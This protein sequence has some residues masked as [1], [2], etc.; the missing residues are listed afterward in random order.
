MTQ[1]RD[2]ERAQFEIFK[3]LP[4]DTPIDMLNL[5]QFHPQAEYPAD[6]PLASEDLTGAQA[7]ANYGAGSGP[8][9]ARVGCE[10]IW[11][12]GFEV[13]LIGGPDEHWDTMFIAHYPNAGAFLAMVTDPD[14]QKAV[15]HRQAAVMDSRLIRTTPLPPSDIFA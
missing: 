14:Y 15:V 6:H 12:G 2:T 13:S 11:R 10:I 7:Y 5:V 9:M 4:R 3:S 1:Y 8:V